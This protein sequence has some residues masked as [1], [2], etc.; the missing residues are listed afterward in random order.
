M[1]SQRDVQ[2]TLIG[3]A[4]GLPNIRLTNA[5]LRRWPGGS[6]AAAGLCPA[7]FLRCGAINLWSARSETGGQIAPGSRI[8]VTAASPGASVWRMRNVLIS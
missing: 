2:G 3:R 6:R 7:V 1:L 5:A 4:P 8:S